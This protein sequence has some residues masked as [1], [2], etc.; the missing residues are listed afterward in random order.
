MPEL[1]L[2]HENPALD[3]RGNKAALLQAGLIAT[4]VAL[5]SVCHL[6]N[7][8]FRTSLPMHWPVMLA[9]LAYGWRSGLAVGFI[10][11]LVSFAI[12]G[13]PAPMALP[14]MCPELTVYGFAAGFARQNLRLNGYIALMSA[15]IAGRLAYAACAT[16]LLNI[17]ITATCAALTPGLYAAIAQIALLPGLA[18]VWTTRN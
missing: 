4:A 2:R 10:S 15:A 18:K 6:M 3:W 16:F 14:L 7:L 11:P 17:P 5:P 8:S 12:S 1:A 9:G 13:M